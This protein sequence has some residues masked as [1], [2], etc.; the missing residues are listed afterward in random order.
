[1]PPYR[2]PKDRFPLK[3]LGIHGD[4]ALLKF[5][6]D[7]YSPKHNTWFHIKSVPYLVRI[8]RS[9]IRLYNRKGKV[10]FEGDVGSGL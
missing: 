1:M 2:E 4:E 3:V 7:I 5:G 8:D 9:S 10:V 6:N